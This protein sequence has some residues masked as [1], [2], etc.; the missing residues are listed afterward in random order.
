MCSEPREFKKRHTDDTPISF[1]LNQSRVF[2]GR[3]ITICALNNRQF[4][5]QMEEELKYK[6][7]KFS[8]SFKPIACCPS[9]V[10]EI[11]SLCYIGNNKAVFYQKSYLLEFVCVGTL[12]ILQQKVKLKYE[13]MC[14]VC[15]GD[16]IYAFDGNVVFT[17]TTDGTHVCT[18][19]SLPKH[20]ECHVS[21]K[22]SLTVSD[23]EK[24]IYCL[25]R[26]ICVYKLNSNNGKVVMGL[27]LRRLQVSPHLTQK[28]I[29]HSLVRNVR[30]PNVSEISLSPPVDV[31]C[32]GNGQVIVCDKIGHVLKVNSKDEYTQTKIDDIKR[33][34]DLSYTSFDRKTSSLIV[35]DDDILKLF[36]LK[37][38]DEINL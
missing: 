14:L 25:D 36:T 31:Y 28:A 27:D 37:W 33:S 22:S 6:F 13:A 7:Y 10:S 34:S 11:T 19:T 3:I 30:L 12:K 29:D 4:L 18:L 8:E 1:A 16:M 15:H 35:V 20:K 32:I 38:N 9:Q 26:H 2:K 21:S 5:A 24:F 23:D 17:C